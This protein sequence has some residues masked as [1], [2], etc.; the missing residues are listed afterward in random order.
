MI[1]TSE[2][3]D[4]LVADAKPVRRLRPPALRAL[5]W[6]LFSALILVLVAFG[7]GV[8]P[9]LLLKLRQPVFAAGLAAAL[10]TGVLAAIASFMASVPGRS[11]WWQLLPAPA[12]AA[13]ISTIGYGC[14]TDWVSMGPEGM[15]PGE[16]ARCFATL[17]LT[18]IPLSLV[19]L[20]MLRYMAR[21]SP[22]PV[23]M[24]GSLA[25]AAM[26]AVALSL[27][28][29]IDATVLIL[30]WNFGVAAL[31]LTFSGLYGKRLLEWLAGYGGR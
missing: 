3:I 8:R 28:H 6:L 5:C 25:V 11:R 26:T 2:V 15:S 1:S 4:S 29:P 22:V 17:A 27:F 18:S 10:A 12:L 24:M 31:F 16:T 19:Q 21:L 30:F 23:A 7:H 14:L 20:F 13:W 9:D